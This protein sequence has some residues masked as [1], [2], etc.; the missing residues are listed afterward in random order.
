LL[1]TIDYPF[2]VVCLCC[3]F[4]KCIVDRYSK[5]GC[6]SSGMCYEIRSL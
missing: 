1:S 2:P 5:Y 4:R 6:R 3:E